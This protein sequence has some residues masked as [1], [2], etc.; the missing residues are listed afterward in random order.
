MSWRNRTGAIVWVG[1]IA[2]AVGVVA[3]QP[4]GPKG[5]ASRPACGLLPIATLG[6]ALSDPADGSQEEEP[7]SVEGATVNVCG[8]VGAELFARLGYEFAWLYVA[9]LPPDVSPE[10]AVRDLAEARQLSSDDY[11]L[12]PSG[13]V[14][15]AS[16]FCVSPQ[17]SSPR[18]Y[19]CLAAV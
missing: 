19:R 5:D 1:L 6:E 3:S 4:P 18:Q 8:Y 9:D 12:E 13:D 17:Q 10:R 7:I 14:G 16:R 2:V 11:V 15:D